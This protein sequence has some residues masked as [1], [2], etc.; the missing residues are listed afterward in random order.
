L[1]ILLEE[2]LPMILVKE[3]AAEVREL[4]ERKAA[5]GLDFS[6]YDQ[7]KLDF[8]LRLIDYTKS[9]LWMS[10]EGLRKKLKDFLSSGYSYTDTARKH[11]VSIR[12]M[13]D[14]V[15][16]ADKCLKKRIGSAFE[17]LG[18]G[19]LVGAE[20]EFAVGTGSASSEMFVRDVEER[21][22]PIKN[23]GVSLDNCKNEI[24]FL[25]HFSKRYLDLVLGHFD[26]QKI[27]HLLYI[28]NVTD[29]SY[30]TPRGVLFRYLEGDLELDE[31]VALLKD[32]VARSTPTISDE[33]QDGTDCSQWF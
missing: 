15:G 32:E 26:R 28:L 11:G 29:M 21:Y 18:E 25:Y 24:H 27:E 13:H 19:D 14:S 22:K 7:K 17:L 6:K 30:I 1:I 2:D 20:R 8:L 4:Y 5:V 9:Y 3:L 23:V 31:A 16:Y 33:E 10:H 12:S